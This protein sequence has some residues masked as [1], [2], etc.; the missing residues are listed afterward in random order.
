MHAGPVTSA[1]TDGPLLA[2]VARPC[3]G[4]CAAYSVFVSPAGRV[5]YCGLVGVPTLGARTWMLSGE[6]LA[7]LQR[8][9]AEARLAEIP[10]EAL[11]GC[12]GSQTF[13]VGA[14]SVR[15][16]DGCAGRAGPEPLQRLERQMPALRSAA[17]RGAPGGGACALSEAY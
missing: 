2:F 16:E 8:A 4:A 11:G 5:D 9:V 1:K 10:E 17:A 7:E 13:V 3:E 15:L 6:E 14:E 12:A